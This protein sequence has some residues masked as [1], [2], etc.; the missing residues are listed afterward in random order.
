MAI[1][2]KPKHENLDVEKLINKGGSVPTEKTSET[3]TPKIRLVQ[4]RL[5]DDLLN[6]ID[7]I[8]NQFRGHPKPSR[9]SWILEAI[10]EKID[11]NKG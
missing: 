5:T 2:K 6:E 11:N 9:H 7:S 4:L 1:S 10:I 3:T 8:R